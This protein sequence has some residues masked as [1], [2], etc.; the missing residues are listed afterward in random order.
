[1]AKINKYIVRILI[2]I[3]LVIIVFTIFYYKKNNSKSYKVY[4]SEITQLINKEE[5]D[6]AIKKCIQGLKK[7]PSKP[8]LYF[9]KSEAY[10]SM[11]NFDKAVGTLDYGYKVTGDMKLKEKSKEYDLS[12]DE[13]A[14]YHNTNKNSNLFRPDES[15]FNSNED[16][17]QDD[18]A[19]IGEDYVLPEFPDVYIPNVIIVTE[20][21][22]QAQEI[23]V[24]T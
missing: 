11:K 12:L 23:I 17:I 18:I 2:L 4:I 1:M 13:D 24:P 15:I 19:G 22:T 6:D 14:K 21:A 10:Y 7:Y 16:D 5:Y 20:P 9:K 3:L 8:G